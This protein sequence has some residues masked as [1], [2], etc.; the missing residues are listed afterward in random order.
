MNI[1]LLRHAQAES[2]Y[3]DSQRVL[4]AKGRDDAERLGHFLRSKETAQPEVLWCSPYRR[5]QETAAT[6]LNAWG[7]AVEQRRDEA[8]LEPDMNPASIAEDLL[9]L[10]RDV[11]V[12]GHNPNITIL[13]S[14]L[15]SAERGRMR[16][17]FNTCNMACLS[18]AP[19]P[20]FGEVGPCE[21]NWMLDPRML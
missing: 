11:L 19:I 15:L 5:A 14:L 21:L 13:A 10:E 18:V 8:C 7:G 1:Y 6:I 12:V 17:N 20:N 9:V 3:P 4:S 2:S 16:T